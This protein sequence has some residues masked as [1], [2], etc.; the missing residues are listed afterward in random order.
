MLAV[1][2]GALLVAW[3]CTPADGRAFLRGLLLALPVA[4]STL[5]FGIVGG[6][7]SDLATRRG[8]PVALLVLIAVWV[9]RAAGG[10]GL[11]LQAMRLGHR[12]R[13]FPTLALAG[14]I[15]GSSVSVVDFGGA[16]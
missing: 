8:L 5:A 11:K 1:V 6:I 9:H 7:G 15:L 4:L 13:R 16:A 14:E 3:I 12:L 10:R 2:A